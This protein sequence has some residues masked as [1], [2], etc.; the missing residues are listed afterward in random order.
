MPSVNIPYVGVVEFPDTMSSEDISNVIMT[1]ADIC[2][3][4]KQDNWDNAVL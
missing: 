4:E 2:G 1:P 3:Y